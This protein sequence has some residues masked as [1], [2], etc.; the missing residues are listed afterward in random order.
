M[1][2]REQRAQ[3]E[4]PVGA[5]QGPER[6]GEGD[7]AQEQGEHAAPEHDEDDT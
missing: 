4:E 7:A 6:P 1:C 2:E 3:E 5:G